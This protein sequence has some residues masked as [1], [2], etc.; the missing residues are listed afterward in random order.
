[1]A[2]MTRTQLQGDGKIVTQLTQRRGYTDEEIEQDEDD[3]DEDDDE[4]KQHHQTQCGETQTWRR[5]DRGKER[6]GWSE[7]NV[8]KKNRTG[9]II[10]GL[11]KTKSIGLPGISGFEAF[12]VEPF[13]ESL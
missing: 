1:M 2:L 6:N 13:E 11:R 4:Q 10:R 5:W 3:D 7:T 8:R 9:I 12:M